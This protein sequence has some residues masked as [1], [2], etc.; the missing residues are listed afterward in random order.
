M[1]HLGIPTRLLDCTHAPLVALYFAT[2]QPSLIGPSAVWAIDL[3]W[4][5]SNAARIVGLENASELTAAMVNRLLLDRTE[6]PAIIHVAPD[7]L[8]KRMAAQYG[9]F[10]GKLV[11]DVNF[12]KV[13]VSMLYKSPQPE[14][15]VVRKVRIPARARTQLMKSLNAANI[16]RETL[17]PQAELDPPGLRVRE[18]LSIR[19]KESIVEARA[20]WERVGE[21]LHEL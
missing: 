2:E 17:F 5:E 11:D 12:A 8:P 3:E 6:R 20:A 16:T 9:L 19:I 14:R 21:R 18:E 15:P 7:E 4:I 1:Q 10:L 13:L